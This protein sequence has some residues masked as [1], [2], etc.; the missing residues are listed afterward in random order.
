MPHL[1]VV[2]VMGGGQASEAAC[3]LG[4]LVAREGWVLLNG[5]RA[6][7]IMEATAKGAKAEGGLTVGILPDDG[8]KYTSP[9]IDIAICT[10][11]GSARNT[12]NVLSSHVIIACQGGL[13]TLSEVAL[14]LKHGRPVIL[15]G[16]DPGPLTR[17]HAPPGRL[18]SA[19]TPEEAVQKAREL[20]QET[21]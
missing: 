9:Y 13:G 4:Q 1:I 16:L 7:G 15:L 18:F 10:G 6:S 8:P 17:T 20:L 21:V 19:R 5:G 14:A 12:I 11:M 3:R 2:G